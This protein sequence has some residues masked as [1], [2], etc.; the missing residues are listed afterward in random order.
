MPQDLTDIN[1]FIDGCHMMRDG[2]LERVTDADLQFAP[3]GDNLTFG[4]LLKELGENQHSY[5]QSLITLKQD[6]TYR[7]DEPGLTIS[8]QKL[9]GWFAGLDAQMKDALT[10]L[11]ADDLQK[12]VDRGKGTIRSVTR[13][14]GIYIEMMLI[15]LGK[16][17]VYFRGMGKPL[18]PSIAEY[19]G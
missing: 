6:W 17:V 13:Q 8:L 2:A 7:N 9:N 3:G 1:M 19:I 15:F 18:P 5:I 4:Q 12:Q 10:G 11:D 16:V 14:L